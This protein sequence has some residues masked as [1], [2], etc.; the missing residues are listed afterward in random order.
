M[1]TRTKKNERRNTNTGGISVYECNQSRVGK[2]GWDQAGGWLQTH[3]FVYSFHVQ[4]PVIC[5]T[6]KTSK[7]HKI[8]MKG[9]KQ[10]QTTNRNNKIKPNQ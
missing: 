1:G 5:H 7:L 6:L 10:N 9:R 3:Y 4:N 2:T 8:E